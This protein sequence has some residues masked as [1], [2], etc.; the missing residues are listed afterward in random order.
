MHRLWGLP[1]P[2]STKGRTKSS[3]IIVGKMMKIA[4]SVPILIVLLLTQTAAAFTT[5]SRLTRSTG[6]RLQLVKS[7]SHLS[8]E[9]YGKLEDSIRYPSLPS[10]AGFVTGVVGFVSQ[11]VAAADDYE[12]AE[13]PP[14]YVPALFGVVLLA[15][16]GVLT[17]SLGNVMDEGKITSRVSTS[18]IY[19]Y[20]LRLEIVPNSDAAFFAL[21]AL[22]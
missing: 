14:P 1:L 8:G 19:I 17:S 11:G 10:M 6:S 18:K 20:I 4:N 3:R 2:L 13:L 22:C 16:V 9:R 12:L 15:G 5:P 7:S 21:I